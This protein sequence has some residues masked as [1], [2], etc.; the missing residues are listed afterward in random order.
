VRTR[1][2]LAA[3]FA[4]LAGCG[5]IGAHGVIREAETAVVRARAAGGERLAPYETASAELYLEKAREEQGRAQY[6]AAQ[7]LARQSLT[8]AR[9]AVDRAGEKGTSVVPASDS[10]S[11]P[12]SRNP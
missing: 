12:T 7:D 9:Q 11:A 3:L 10:T 8:Y 1:I 2:P 6:G 4:L 5:P